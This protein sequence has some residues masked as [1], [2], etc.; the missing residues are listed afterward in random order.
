MAQKSDNQFD[1][2]PQAGSPVPQDQDP[3]LEM[4]DDLEEEDEF[5]DE[6]GDEED[7]EEE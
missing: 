5:D 6:V 1:P 7:V 3:D 2:H 4:T